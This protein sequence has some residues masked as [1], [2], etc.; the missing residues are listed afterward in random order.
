MN[1]EA[2]YTQFHYCSLMNSNQVNNSLLFQDTGCVKTCELYLRTSS[3]R[4]RNLKCY[5][6][7][8]WPNYYPWLKIRKEETKEFAAIFCFIIIFLE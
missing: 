6:N 4:K 5:F 2:K 8:G 1:K 3:F 7:I